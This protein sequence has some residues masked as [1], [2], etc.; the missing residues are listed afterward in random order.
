MR[1]AAEGDDTNIAWLP[2]D[3]RY[4]EKLATPT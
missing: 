2:R 1:V 3:A 4:V